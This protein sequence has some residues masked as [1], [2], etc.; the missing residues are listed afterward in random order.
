MTAVATEPCDRLDRAARERL[1]SGAILVFRGAPAVAALV[2]LVRQRILEA[3]APHDPPHV[4]NA[5]DRAGLTRRC[6]ALTERVEADREIAAALD[7]ALASLGAD[8]DRT[9]RDRMRLRIQVSGGD[10]DGRRPMTLPPHRDTWGSNV[11]AQVNWWA[12][13]FAIDERR[14]VAFWPDLFDRA[15]AN[16]SGDWD[17]DALI[18]SRRRGETD[19]P[20][21]PRCMTSDDLGPARPAVIDVGDL[22]AF[23]GAHL[24]AG[25]VNG[26]GL[27]RYSLEVRSVDR[28]DLRSGRGARNVDGGAPR[29]PLHWFRRLA[30]GTILDAVS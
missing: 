13:L 19:Y 10:L 24:H 30:D 12:P 6:E 26:S 23:S 15:V 11:M 17:Y 3:M 27:V 20:L 18:A 25:T 16:T 21:L 4:Q 5:L 9:F 29:T 28:D 7:A 2:E 22:M 8:P 14:T 1:F